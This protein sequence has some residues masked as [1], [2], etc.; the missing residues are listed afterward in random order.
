MA[1]S[2]EPFSRLRVECPVCGSIN[3]YADIRPLSYRDTGSDTDFHPLGR[4]WHNAAYQTYDPLWFFMATC[5]KC[6]YTRE[7]NAEFKGWTQDATFKAY[8]QAAVRDRHLAASARQNGIVQ[9]LGSHIDAAKHPK[10]SAIIRLVLGIYDELTTDRTSSLNV[11]RYYLR[12]AWLFR[13]QGTP[14]ETHSSP[15]AAVL[16]RLR[17]MVSCADHAL[18][19]YD[20]TMGDLTAV[21]ETDVTSMVK[22]TT[23]AG[24]RDQPKVVLGEIAAS[25]AALL[26][27]HSELTDVCDRVELAVPA[28]GSSG[29]AFHTFASFGQFLLKAKQLWNDVPVTEH[30]ALV[31]ACEHYRKAYETG[32]DIKE[33]VPQ[34]QAAYLIGEL[35]RRT[36]D[37]KTAE[38]YF[39]TVMKVGGRLANSGTQDASTVNRTRKLLELGRDQAR[40][41]Q[42]AQ[43]AVEREGH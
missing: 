23:E 25:I 33:G 40:L 35:S 39:D 12:T 4:V 19:G 10:E 14:V 15:T 38:Q 5:A 1:N 24:L 36:G 22:D 26:R 31:R 37:F 34:V 32:S 42:D 2:P 13:S 21:F 16:K 8:R 41:N 29:S 20:R 3:E 27:A 30:E 9:F 7:L 11:G 6:F 43:A 18:R 28:D 17:A